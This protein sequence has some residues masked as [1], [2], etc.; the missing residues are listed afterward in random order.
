VQG[1]SSSSVAGLR[2]QADTRKKLQDKSRRQQVSG[3]KPRESLSACRHQIMRLLMLDTCSSACRHHVVR[4]PIFMVVGPFFILL[5]PTW[6][7]WALG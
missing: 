5:L 6:H 4:K 3:S 2:Q 1:E 7:S